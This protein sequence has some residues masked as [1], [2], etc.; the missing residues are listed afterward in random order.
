[1]GLCEKVEEKAD[2]TGNGAGIG[3][4]GEENG[5]TL[6]HL[7]ADNNDFDLIPYLLSFGPS[8]FVDKPCNDGKTALERA[9]DLNGKESIEL[10]SEPNYTIEEFRNGTG[11]C[12]RGDYPLQAGLGGGTELILHGILAT[13]ENLG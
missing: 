4:C 1:M 10:L 6:L 12:F 9:Q 13:R 5:D 7:A 8:H 11:G 2:E 3:Y